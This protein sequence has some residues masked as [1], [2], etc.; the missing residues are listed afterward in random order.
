MQAFLEAAVDENGKEISFEQFKSKYPIYDFGQN[1][2]FGGEINDHYIEGLT[3]LGF[4]Q[5]KTLFKELLEVR[6]EKKQE[7]DKL[8]DSIIDTVK[9]ADGYTFSDMSRIYGLLAQFTLHEMGKTTDV[10]GDK[11]IW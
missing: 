8:G 9:S 10:R 3:K 4:E 5:M 1:H 2:R 6:E 7:T 11:V